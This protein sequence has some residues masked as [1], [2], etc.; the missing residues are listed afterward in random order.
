MST[1]ISTQTKKPSPKAKAK[2]VEDKP[3]FEFK[4]RVYVWKA[5]SP[6]NVLLRTQHTPRKPM[7]YFDGTKTRA[8]RYC[9]NHESPFIDEQKGEVHLGRIR[10][11]N[12]TLV[13]PKE[14]VTL[15]KFLSIY[16]PDK[17]KLY[18]ELDVEKDA[19]DDL[20]FIRMESEATTLALQMDINDLEAIARA[21]FRSAV[22]NMRSSEIRRDM[23]IYAKD[24]PG[25]FIKLANDENVK[26]RNI[27]IRSVEMGILTILSDN[28]TVCWNDKDKTKIMS[29]PFGE[30]VYSALAKFFKTDEGVEVLQGISNKL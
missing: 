26:N 13:V 24:N 12:G 10:M 20:D 9:Q 11:I 14:D 17:D 2:V 3:A 30:N 4:D 18:Y 29:A 23:V 8:I 22:N 19:M 5:G 7:Q 25:E 21:V 27:A 16:H 28:Q 15:Q 6:V 1:K